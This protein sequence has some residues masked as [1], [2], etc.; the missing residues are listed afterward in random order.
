M[1]LSQ[2]IEPFSVEKHLVCF[3]SFAILNNDT[4]TAVYMYL[5]VFAK[6]ICGINPWKL[7][8]NCRSKGMLPNYFI[9]GLD[10]VLFT[11]FERTHFPT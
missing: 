2:V 9:K 7:N 10:S 11:G 5:C 6:Y 3:W 8:L 1:A 4:M